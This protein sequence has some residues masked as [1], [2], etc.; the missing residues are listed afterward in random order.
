MS[1]K[2]RLRSES[3]PDPDVTSNVR[4]KFS[5]AS[6]GL[7]FDRSPGKVFGHSETASL[8]SSSLLGLCFHLSWMKKEQ[9][10]CGKNGWCGSERV[11]GVVGGKELLF[12]ITKCQK[13]YWEIYQ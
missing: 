10:S 5:L 7:V 9:K 12:S 3:L 2:T 13:F 6:I 8:G 11:N 4:K 1:R